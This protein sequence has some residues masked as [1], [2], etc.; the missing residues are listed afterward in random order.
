[1]RVAP[2][3]VAV[4]V[5]V[6][7]CS[8]GDEA[9]DTTVPAATVTP[10]PGTVAAAPSAAPTPLPTTLAPATP[11]PT[12]AVAPPTTAA[13]TTAAPID[14]AA[15]LA[16][17]LDQL[18]PGYHFVTTATVG[19]QVAVSAE[20]DHVAGS[21]R[22]TLTSSGTAT[23]YLIAGDAAWAFADGAWQE[24]DPADS[25]SDPL[26]ALRAP[27][28]VTLVAGDATAATV[29]ATYPA[30]ALGLPG[31]TESTVEFQLANGA[32]TALTYVADPANVSAVIT[33]IDPA[34]EITLPTA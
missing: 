10:S 19:G 34:T 20:G 27:T 18:A 6:A 17:A 16:T 30:S 1:M 12:T 7:G 23:D 32:I 15:L 22:M 21:T 24:L 8:R 9:S 25:P 31:D 33:P 13:P 29:H 3:A 14:P 2:L 5:T 11:A 4:L 28:A 26:A